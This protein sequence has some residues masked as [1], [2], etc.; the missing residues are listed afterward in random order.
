MFI[1]IAQIYFVLIMVLA[2][3]FFAFTNAHWPH[4]IILFVLLF[5]G[6]AGLLV[7]TEELAENGTYDDV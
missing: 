4:T 7:T 6:F 5:V 3:C 1:R 2:W